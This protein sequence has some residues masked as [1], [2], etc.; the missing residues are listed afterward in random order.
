VNRIVWRESPVQ[1]QYRQWNEEDRERA[2]AAAWNGW[3]DDR[4]D[5]SP[6]TPLPIT[7]VRDLARVMFDAGMQAARSEWRLR[8]VV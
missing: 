7:N 4:P 6:V 2:A 5:G 3:F 1:A 8:D